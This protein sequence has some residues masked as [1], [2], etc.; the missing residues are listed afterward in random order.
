[1][2]N[3]QF[4]AEQLREIIREEVRGA[5][6]E[7]IKTRELPPLLT[8]KEMMDLLRIK[9]TKAAELLGRPDFPVFREA[10]VLIPTDKLFQWID[11]HT[12]WV[13]ENTD[14]FKSV[15]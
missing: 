1:M 2:F 15:S 4:D 14:F 9:P 13:E 12:Y 6:T 7:S 3:V 11:K 5:L 8:R 10:G